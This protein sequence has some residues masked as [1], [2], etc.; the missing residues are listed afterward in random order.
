MI[1]LPDAQSFVLA[2]CT[3]L[4]PRR[5]ALDDALGC[6]VSDDIMATEAVPPFANS[7][8][9]GYALAAAKGYFTQLTQKSGNSTHGPPW[10]SGPPAPAIR[11]I[12]KAANSRG[13]RTGR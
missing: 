7:S 4:P 1:P 9:D 10:W 3:P 8:M 13:M 12:R 2:Q 11:A 6:V 5:I